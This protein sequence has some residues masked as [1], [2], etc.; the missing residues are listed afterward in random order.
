MRSAR[1]T[2][3]KTQC[4]VENGPTI[5]DAGRENRVTTT[6]TNLF[7]NINPITEPSVAN[8]LLLVIELTSEEGKHYSTIMMEPS[9]VQY[10]DVKGSHRHPHFQIMGTMQY[11]SYVRD[12]SDRCEREG[13][14]HF[15]LLTEEEVQSGYR[16]DRCIIILRGDKDYDLDEV[17][18][19]NNLHLCPRLGKI[20]ET[21]PAEWYA[22]ILFG[23]DSDGKR[24][25]G[26]NSNMRGNKRLDAGF[27]GTNSTD[28]KTV[29][30]MNIPSRMTSNSNH[31]GVGEDETREVTIFKSGCSLLKLHDIF[32]MGMPPSSA[33][34]GRTFHDPDW[35]YTYS[36]RWGSELG[37]MGT[38]I[39]AYARFTGTSIIACGA[40]GDYNLIKARKHVDKNNSEDPGHDHSPTIM[41]LV[42]LELDDGTTVTVR[43]GQ[44]IYD[45]HVCGLQI[46]KKRIN[47]EIKHK[48]CMT[49]SR[50]GDE[51]TTIANLHRKFVM[52]NVT[53]EGKMV[54]FD[55]ERGRTAWVYPEDVDKDGYYSLFVNVILDICGD[56]VDSKWLMMEMLLTLTLNPCPLRWAMACYEA[57]ELMR[58]CLDRQGRRRSVSPRSTNFFCCFVHVQVRKFGTVSGGGKFR[59]CQVSHGS[60][61]NINDVWT[62]LKNLSVIIDEAD[63]N[64]SETRKLVNKLSSK[65]ADGGC[66]G[67]GLFW[68]QAIINVCVKL[69]LIKTTRHATS[70]IIATSTTTY[71]RL[72]KQ[73]VIN[74]T[75]AR[76]LVGWLSNELDVPMDRCENGLCLWLRELYG[77]SDTFDC[78]VQGHKL[79]KVYRGVIAVFNRGQG[80]MVRA[81]HEPGEGTYTASCRWW[82]GDGT[83]SYVLHLKRGRS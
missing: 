30:G 79:Y 71:K 26:G 21:F 18:V 77:S 69:K 29:P 50:Q 16:S 80:R 56:Y 31:P 5:I 35:H 14:P 2:T 13:I 10:Y 34:A 45:K 22:K 63:E 12:L 9:K 57:A 6:Y 38:S 83:D 51:V 19:R 32:K 4:N 43:I 52:W 42:T 11:G 64:N 68:A 33:M 40:D 27:T 61:Y 47:M 66:V 20:V 53:E 67:V 81:K 65:P 23:D 54:E 70:P 76:D 15:R 59:R 55:D 62:S 75:H 58:Q 78:F 36:Y 82:I 1:Q 74:A 7:A 73:G 25:R 37:L 49:L 48:V 28:N 72:I 41:F 60:K 8:D 24:G 44:N 17:V 3:I 39:M 46:K